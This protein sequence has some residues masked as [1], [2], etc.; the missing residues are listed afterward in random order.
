MPS[1][2]PAQRF[3]AW[4]L[5]RY[6]QVIEYSRQLLEEI[7][8][9][10][11][12]HTG[13]GQAPLPAGILFGQGDRHLV[14]LL[15]HR[16]F[17]WDTDPTRCLQAFN[18]ALVA[19]RQEPALQSMVPVGWY[20]VVDQGQLELT[21]TDRLLA[22]K[23]LVQSWQLVLLIQARSHQPAQAAI[24]LRSASGHWPAAPAYLSDHL[25][26][27]DQPG[28]PLQRDSN[29]GSPGHA[30][31]PAHLEMQPP[32]SSPLPRAAPPWAP[33]A[34]PQLPPATTGPRRLRRWF[35]LSASLLLIVGIVLAAAYTGRFERAPVVVRELLA[36]A[37]QQLHLETPAASPLAASLALRAI[38]TPQGLL[39]R[40]DPDSNS[41]K[42]VTRAELEIIDG[43]QPHRFELS[44]GQLY[45]GFYLYEPQS[46]DVRVQ[47]KLEL[48]GQ[49]PLTE[50]TR[51]LSS[52][53]PVVLQP[54]LTSEQEKD[55]LAR[56]VEELR[57]ALRVQN[58]EAASLERTLASLRRPAAP[59]E[60]VQPKPP[61]SPERLVPPEP[62]GPAVR[63]Q[64][65]QPAFASPAS[66]EREGR[67]LWTGLLQPRAELVIQGNSAS[68]GTVTGRLPGV[69]VSVQVYPAR[70]EPEGL[71]AL[72]SD[73]RY[74]R[75]PVVEPPG[76]ENA[77]NRTTYRWDP[78]GS[79]MVELLEAPGPANN[80]QRLRLRATD[81]PVT[82]LL[83]HWR[84]RE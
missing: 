30:G 36:A 60:V 24:F 6:P 79:R 39:I 68:T 13:T 17:A 61:S 59:G 1:P 81:R 72:T 43:E 15:E 76:P 38:H 46:A 44:R 18:Q 27:P 48:S 70:L 75:Q 23:F 37:R 52:V 66:R 57:I 31:P 77:W 84:L 40:W 22:E 14:R 73:Q 50:A 54:P 2:R 11:R 53:P 58:E 25:D 78:D 12:S 55:R 80:W 19:A 42:D 10:A 82:L 71:V 29:L 7:V 45:S 4:R 63:L 35:V 83:I 62:Q 65:H 21:G 33:Q 47:L 32:D 26:Q 20:R 56:E 3:G 34:P 51:F 5:A 8:A 9:Q 41:L 74:A 64:Q 16:P 69:P 28:V 67:L 49:E